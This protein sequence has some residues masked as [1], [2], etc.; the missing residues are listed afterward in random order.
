MISPN[1]TK[2]GT[3][4]VLSCYGATRGSRTL[5]HT[6]MGMAMPVLMPSAVGESITVNNGSSDLSRSFSMIS[7][8]DT[9]SNIMF[10]TPGSKKAKVLIDSDD[11]MVT[12]LSKIE[13]QFGMSTTSLDM[14]GMDD[15]LQLQQ[16]FIAYTVCT[17]RG[18]ATH[19]RSIAERI[20][21]K[22]KE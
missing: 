16:Y 21:K 1:S 9:N 11:G 3:T 22:S 5:S 14:S 13:S 19:P 6:E 15:Y 10:F 18:C 20:R 8:G 7:S 2:S 12:S 17:K 4:H